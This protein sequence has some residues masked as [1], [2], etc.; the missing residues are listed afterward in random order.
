MRAAAEGLAGTIRVGTVHCDLHGA[1]CRDQMEGRDYYPIVK[2]F[3]S[4]ARSGIIDL[5]HPELPAAA[6][7]RL[8]GRVVEVLGGLPER[9]AGP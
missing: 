3:A 9:R 7:L 4:S 1:L 8:V 2:L 6:V 5:E